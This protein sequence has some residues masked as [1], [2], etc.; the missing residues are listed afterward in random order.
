MKLINF[1]KNRETERK[2]KEQDRDRDR[3][4][5]IQR[6]SYTERQRDRKLFYQIK[7][8]RLSISQFGETVKHLMFEFKA[9]TFD[10]LGFILE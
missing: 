7:S 6:D 10:I 9:P 5:A 4:T 2:K 3:E 1:V 8:S